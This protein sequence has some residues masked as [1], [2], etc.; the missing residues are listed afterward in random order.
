MENPFLKRA[1]EMLRDEEA[2]LAMI[3]PEPVKHFLSRPGK[4]GLL[5]DR[6]VF[7]RGTP[8]SGK[9][10]LATLFEYPTLAALLRNRNIPSHRTLVAALV[11]CGAITAGAPSLLGCRL[12]METDYRDFW[13]FP[14]RDELKLSLMTTLVQAR[15]VLGWIRNL[16]SSGI[17]L[18][19]IEIVPRQDAEAAMLAV[20]GTAGSGL[21]ERARAVEL[22]LYGI[23]GALVAPDVSKLNP[24]STQA[25]RP[26]D[27]IDQFRVQVGSGDDKRTLELRPLIILD[28]AHVLHP[29]QYQGVKSWLTRRE[30]RVARWVLTRIDVMHPDEALAAITEDRNE[31]VQLPGVTVTRE[32]TEIMLQSGLD[33]RRVQRSAFRRM[34]KDMANRYLRKMPIFHSRGLTSLSDLMNTNVEPIPPSKRKELEASVE[35]TKNRLSISDT[36]FAKIEAEVDSYNPTGGKLPPDIRLGMINILMHRYAKRIPQQN[37]FSKEVDPEPNK[38]L[39]AESTVYDA[40]RIQLLHKYD[41]PYY[42]GIDDLCDAGSENAEQFLRLAAV[43]VETAETRL[44]RSQQPS[45]DA[46]SQNRLLRKRADEIIDA[47][48]FP[49]YQLVRHVTHNIADQCL[50]ETLLPNAWLGAGP[51]AYGIVQE[52]FDEIPGK[53]PDLA[54]VLQFGFAYNAFNVVPRYPCKG[55][56]WCLL[57]L[58]GM[59]TLKY[60]LSLKRGNFLEGTA[61]ELNGL[62]KAATQ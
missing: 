34:A 49:Q 5:Y 12:P 38:A 13:E 37:L 9:T 42:V 2:F 39:T 16:T 22:A 62:I 58:G 61:E 18:D 14:Y 25:Y 51:N 1:T 46:A 21:L 50:A 52:E 31:R 15:A 40:A 20:G 47:W 23:V 26:F 10:T 30:L 59:I 35:A 53:Y 60:G 11:D 33:D 41:R 36:R 8:G 54:R 56:K 19:D 32:T 57:E 43:I 28:D 24:D 44:V 27:V 7:V 17:A 48:N 45:I 6:L 29:A 3:T 55:K 4:A